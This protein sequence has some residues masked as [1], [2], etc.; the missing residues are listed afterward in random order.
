MQQRILPGRG[1]GGRSRK[2][3]SGRDT[4]DRASSSKAGRRAPKRSMICC[5]RCCGECAE[6]WAVAG[7]MSTTPSSVHT[8]GRIPEPPPSNKTSRTAPP[9]LLASGQRYRTRLDGR[10]ARCKDAAQQKNNLGRGATRE[11]VRVAAGR[12][13][14]PR[15]GGAWGE[16]QSQRGEKRCSSRPTTT[17]W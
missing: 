1:S 16:A 8:P 4:L 5:I 7:E 15:S 6:I 11:A 2:R 12:L 14:T 17:Y 9:P 10:R 13:R 3:L